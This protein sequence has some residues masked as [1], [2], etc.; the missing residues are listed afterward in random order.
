MTINK[1]TICTH[2]PLM[3]KVFFQKNE[4]KKKTN[5]YVIAHRQHDRYIYVFITNMEKH[6]VHT[7]TI[8]Q[9]EMY[10]RPCYKT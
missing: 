10:T 8:L 2:A 1:R 3:S 5:A 7:Q 4:K 9:I 6:F